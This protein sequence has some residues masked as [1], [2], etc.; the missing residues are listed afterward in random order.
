ME[1]N[2]SGLLSLIVIL[3]PVILIGVYYKLHIVK[4][5]LTSV[6]RMTIQ[7][8]AVGLV[9]QYVFKIENPWIN[10]GYA[11][12]M[13]TVAAFNAIHRTKLNYKRYG[14][15]IFAS[16]FLS[17]GTILF[18]FNAF[19]VQLENLFVAQYM[20]TVTGMLLGNALTGIII[21]MNAFFSSVKENHKAYDYTLAQG[22]SRREALL[23]YIR[24]ALLSSINPN[25]SSIETIGLV[26]LPG[27]MNGQILAG[28]I[29][30][31]AI[32]YQLAI[33]VAILGVSF[34][35]SWL[36]IVLCVKRAFND[37]DVMI[38]D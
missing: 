38:Q 23:P 19:V 2:Y 12:F 10:A 24:H 36:A 7:L 20:V 4:R 31:T 17:V 5:T 22:A 30:L 3:I 15:A 25:L 29:P 34:I 33:M 8:A 16:F 32:K 18:F 27:M 26:A 11:L 1:L 35:G 13:I 14:L 37:Y 9:L 6:F 28:S 21:T